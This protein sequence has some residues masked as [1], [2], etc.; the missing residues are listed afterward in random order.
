MR[1]IAVLALVVAAVAAFYFILPSDETT[2]QTALEGVSTPTTPEEAPTTAGETELA[3][4]DITPRGQVEGRTDPVD[5]ETPTAA[6]TSAGL[7]GVIVGPDEK[8]LE[9]AR[10][11][12]TRHG[13]TSALFIDPTDVDRSRDKRTKTNAA[14]QYSFTRVEPF[15]RYALLISHP[16]FAPLEEG[17]I[18]IIEGEMNELH[19]IQLSPGVSLSGT[20]HDSLG[21]IVPK[22]E[23][24]LGQMALAIGGGVDPNA[25]TAVANDAGEYQFKNLATGNFV[26]QI[27]A[28]GYGQVTLSQI[29]VAGD[30]DITRDITLDIAMALGGVVTDQNGAPLEKVK[31]TAYSIGNREN[32]TQ[33]QAQTDAKGEFLMHDVP[34]GNY[35]LRASAT[36]FRI[37][38]VARAEAGDMNLQIALVNLPKVSGQVVDAGTGQPLRRFSVSLRFAG[39]DKVNTVRIGKPLAIT[40][41]Q[42]R[43]TL[44]C[45]KAG[46]FMVQAE[47]PD[48]AASLSDV[49]AIAASQDLGGI[50]VRCTKGGGIRG[51]VMDSS[52]KPVPRAKVTTRDDRWTGSDFDISLGIFPGIATV[53]TSRTNS[54]GEFSIDG[55]TPTTYLVEIEHKQFS[56]TAVRNVIVTEGVAV[57]LGERVLARGAIV[58]GTVR[59]PSGTVLPGSVVTMMLQPAA[60]EF[61]ARYT[62][63]ANK[64]GGYRIVNARPGTYWIHS[65]RPIRGGGNPFAHSSDIQNTR[66]QITV[67]DGQEL[68][69]QD[70]DLAN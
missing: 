48:H 69:G 65:T 35:T 18:V 52:G 6:P 45:P 37:G 47:A 29:H 15:E 56:G 30:G 21:N 51:I 53:K 64:D 19:P 20:V 67:T 44:P 62:A 55:L 46:N 63:K 13:T 61:P 50:T 27:T 2:T 59:G 68:Q 41:D 31:V 22:A 4:D 3:G 25:M 28:D 5:L 39:A 11:V 36:G 14:G 9:G 8:P 42:G 32:R 54:R 70:F 10:V 7:T 23:L 24:L 49:F 43:F 58:T 60:D 1:P 33:T 16:D 12:L 40:D 57:E 66:R 17:G 34:A 38:Q 26:L